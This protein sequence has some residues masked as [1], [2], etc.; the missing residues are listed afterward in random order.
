MATNPLRMLQEE[1][2]RVESLDE[3]PPDLRH[4]LEL[5]ATAFH[6]TPE[7]MRENII[8]M[9]FEDNLTMGF[10]RSV[11]TGDKAKGFPHD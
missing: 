11:P 5:L 7:A 4:A 10:M 6:T 8:Y 2:R 9:S 3:L 1:L